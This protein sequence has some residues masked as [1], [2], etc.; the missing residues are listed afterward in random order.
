M[1]NR[2]KLAVVALLACL[3]FAIIATPASAFQNITQLNNS[4]LL[5]HALGPVTCGQP[6]YTIPVHVVPD[7]ELPGQNAAAH[8]SDFGTGPAGYR[9]C[10]IN[11][12]ATMVPNNYEYGCRVIIHEFGHLHSGAAHSPDPLNI[13]FGGTIGPFAPCLWLTQVAP[14]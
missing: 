9:N 7:S 3:S 12:R 10:Y 8:W 5:A 2:A 6:T 4:I 14:A 11:I 13:M 1:M